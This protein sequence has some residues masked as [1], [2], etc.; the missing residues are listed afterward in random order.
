MVR[1]CSKGALE[2]QERVEAAWTGRNLG[3]SKSASSRPVRW[4]LHLPSCPFRMVVCMSES[5]RDAA[6]MSGYVMHHFPAEHA[7]HGESPPA[8]MHP[9][10]LALRVCDVLFAL[11]AGDACALESMAVIRLLQ[12]ACS[13]SLRIR[14][15]PETAL[16][17]EVFWKT[18]NNAA[19]QWDRHTTHFR[20]MDKEHRLA[21]SI[22]GKDLGQSSQVRLRRQAED[23]QFSVLASHGG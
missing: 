20:S 11:I 16:A 5:V 17:S 4:L 3:L 7:L 13:C 6:A 9:V 21:R 23:G 8:K 1:T 12:H 22:L 15:L 2:G 18:A 14:P 19:S 10:R